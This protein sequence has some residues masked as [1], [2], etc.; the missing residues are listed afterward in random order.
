MAMETG[1]EMGT[2][3]WVGMVGIR[4]LGHILMMA[5]KLWSTVGGTF[6]F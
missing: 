4:F 5:S 1:M 2:G 6:G 3:I